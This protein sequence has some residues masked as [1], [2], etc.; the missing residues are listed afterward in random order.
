MTD[1]DLTNFE[2][3]SALF[4]S[5]M[6]DAVKENNA[7]LGALKEAEAHS[8]TFIKRIY[9]GEATTPVL[10]V[11]DSDYLERCRALDR[12]FCKTLGCV[13]MTSND[14]A[15]YCDRCLLA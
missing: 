11:E 15:G 4:I 8:K 6:R 7:K 9:E 1:Q 13:G 5:E 14:D 12:F 3:S 2:T 10:T